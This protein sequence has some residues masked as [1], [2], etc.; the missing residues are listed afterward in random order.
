MTTRV[1]REA[2][3]STEAEPGRLTKG[4]TSDH[5]ARCLAAGHMV[6]LLS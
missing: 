3:K 2:V 1:T 5:A 4:R 6:A